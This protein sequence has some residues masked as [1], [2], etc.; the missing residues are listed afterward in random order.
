M[1]RV[2]ATADGLRYAIQAAADRVD[3]AIT[4]PLQEATEGLKDELRR[5]TAAVL[6]TRV[7]LTWRSRFYPNPGDQRGPAGF[8]WSKAPRILSFFSADRIVTPLGQAFA[9]PVNPVI[10]SRGRKATVAEVEQQF[11]KLQAVKLKDGNIGLFATLVR[12]RNGRGFRAPTKGRLRQGR[13]AEKVL[14]FILV[15]TIRSAKL[16]DIDAAA[17]RWALRYA[18]MIARNLG[19]NG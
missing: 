4:D 5:E 7:S 9:I 15:K 6:G 16:V 3:K 19:A 18:D 8:V 11:G 17:S 12:A 13:N 10:K 1:L 14:M 2:S